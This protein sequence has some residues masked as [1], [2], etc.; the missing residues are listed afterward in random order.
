MK[1]KSITTFHPVQD[2]TIPAYKI[3][4]YFVCGIIYR[5]I[6]YAVLYTA[7]YANQRAACLLF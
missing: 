7:A 6:L 3:Y 5:I 1:N 2:L 4:H